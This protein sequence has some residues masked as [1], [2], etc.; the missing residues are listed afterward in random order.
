M[1]DPD[2]HEKLDRILDGVVEI[3][4]A[5]GTQ[6]EQIRLLAGALNR[7]IESLTAKERPDEGGRSLRELLADLVGRIELQ[8][9]QLQDVTKVQVKMMHTLP[10]LIAEAVLK[11]IITART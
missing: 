5:V 10:G 3:G 8:N 2:V 1:P 7:L 4:T 9:R 11:A 6:S